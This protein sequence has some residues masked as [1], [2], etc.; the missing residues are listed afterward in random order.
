MF[1]HHSHRAD[2][3][4]L[5]VLLSYG[6]LYMDLD[7][8]SVS[9]FPSRAMSSSFVIGKQ[10]SQVSSWRAKRDYCDWLGSQPSDPNP[11][12]PTLGSQPS[13][14]NPRIPTLGSQLLDPNSSRRIQMLA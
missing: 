6:G 2:L 4:R 8:L 14:P 11:P 9:Q 1:V 10:D 3:L 13:D 7:A 5:R 12:I